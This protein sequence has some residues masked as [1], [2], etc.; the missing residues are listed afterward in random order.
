MNKR[1]PLLA[2]LALASTLAASALTAR[3]Q[4][5]IYWDTSAGGGLG[6]NGAFSSSGVS[7]ATNPAGAANASGGPTGDA[8]FIIT[9][10]ANGVNAWA[11]GNYLLNFGGTAGTVTNGG[12]FQVWGINILTNGYVFTIDGTSNNFRTLTMTNSLDLGANTVTFANGA[13]G[14]NSYTL[15]GP[16]NG[17][18]GGITAT[19]G[20]GIV[21]ANTNPSNLTNFGFYISSGGSV[22]AN[23]PINILTLA[24]TRIML[25]SQSSGGA[26]VGDG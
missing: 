10:N 7:W 9:N 3:A 18:T 25:G 16:A 26:V 8:L 4:T 6:G 5:N 21:I 17:W 11:S 20:A 12:A 23:A 19:A 24:N 22:S 14:T 1:R 13:R 15:A 2:A